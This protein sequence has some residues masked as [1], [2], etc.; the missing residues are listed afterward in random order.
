MPE[1]APEI[2]VR[3][4][5]AAVFV[6]ALVVIIPVL[7]QLVRAWLK[8]KLE[9]IETRAAKA[10]EANLAKIDATIAKTE[11]NSQKIKEIAGEI[12]PQKEPPC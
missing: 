4:D 7:A 8:L 2:V 10:H 5:T 12:A 6:A 9:A 3:P 1:I 11:E